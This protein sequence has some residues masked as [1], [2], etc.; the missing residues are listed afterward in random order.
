MGDVARESNIFLFTNL[1]FIFP[2]KIIPSTMITPGAAIMLHNTMLRHNYGHDKK[3]FKN[4]T[5]ER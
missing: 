3:P 4:F 5:A 1:N 2:C